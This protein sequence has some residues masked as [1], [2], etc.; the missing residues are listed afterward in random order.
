MR[1]A[2]LPPDEEERLRLLHALNLLDS[3][4]EPEFDRITRLVAHILK[5]PIALVSLV[6]AHR[7]WFKSRVGLDAKE[8]AREVAFCAHAILCTKPLL[9]HDASVDER[10]FDNPLVTA[11]PNIRFYAGVPIRSSGGL[12][13]GTLC[14]ID[15]KPRTLTQEEQ[16]ALCDLADIVSKEIQLREAVAMTR[17]QLSRSEQVLKASEARFRT[18][19]ERASVGIALVA[20]NGGW[21]SVNDS[22]CEIVGYRR[23]ELSRLTF[24]DITHPDDLD[25][26]LHLLQKLVAGEIDRYQVEKRYVRKN[27]KPVWVSLNVAKKTSHSGQL[28]YFI[29]V[30]KNIQARK[31]AEESLAE[32][33]RELELRVEQ[34]TSELRKREKELSVV[35]ENANDA[36]V[37]IDERGIV[38]A[39]NQQA[40]Q[41]FGWSAREAIGRALDQLIIPEAMRAAHRNGLSRYLP[42]GRSTI[43]DRRLELTAVR[44]DGSML[45]V[46]VRVR[47]LDLGEQRVFSAFLHDITERKNAEAAREREARHDPLTGLLNR[48]GLMEQLPGAVA[49]SRRA[50]RAL[51]LLFLDLDGFKAVNDTQGHVA[52]DLLLCEIAR[53]LLLCARETDTVARFAGDEF[54]I[55]LEGLKDGETEAVHFAQRIIAAIADPVMVAA[56]V[57]AHIGVSIGVA[58]HDTHHIGD[59][60]DLLRRADEAMYEAKRTGKGRV[61]VASPP[62][63][64]KQVP[65]PG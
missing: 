54:T 30:V 16:D 3:E 47:S 50:D 39:W 31:E 65:E 62:S 10:F 18:V 8:T 19:F 45:P 25:L 46:E 5:V 28:E 14:A 17:S 1:S 13:L 41:T 2:P 40:H 29:S 36:Y 38:T 23:E 12:T 24:Q 34:R 26:D 58:I 60:A 42:G 35:I 59:T 64:D 61:C 27:G 33:R 56:N 6:D 43:L 37:C 52:G 44:R 11:A 53:R 32:L 15:S 22:L 4:P 9:V 57:T 55:V 20:P 51:A 21:I 63:A 49:R 48:R 7:Q